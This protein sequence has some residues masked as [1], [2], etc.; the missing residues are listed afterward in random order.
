MLI[1]VNSVKMG[2]ERSETVDE[3]PPSRILLPRGAEK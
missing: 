3:T 1:G 2:G